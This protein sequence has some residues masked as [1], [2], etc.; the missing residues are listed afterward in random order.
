LGQC[1]YIFLFFNA[2]TMHIKSTIHNNTAMNSL[3]N[4]LPGGN[5]ISSVHISWVYV[6]FLSLP[7]INYTL[8]KLWVGQSQQSIHYLFFYFVLNRMTWGSLFWSPLRA[9]FCKMA[10]Y[11][12]INK[13][14]DFLH[15]WLYIKFKSANILSKKIEAVQGDQR[16]LWK[17]C[18]KCR[19]QH[20]WSQLIH[21][22]SAVKIIGLLL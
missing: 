4:S 14:Y 17:N 19:P 8:G 20:F 10:I 9:I 16:S 1:L 6:K 22:F 2:Q 13:C 18:P 21:E 12:F 5:R 15:K 7:T 3:K 11:V